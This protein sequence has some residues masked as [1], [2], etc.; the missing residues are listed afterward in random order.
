ML[1]PRTA[2]VH[3]SSEKNGGGWCAIVIENGRKQFVDVDR[4][5]EPGERLTLRDGVW[6]KPA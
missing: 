6:S 2:I 1:K 3:R 5:Y 4:R